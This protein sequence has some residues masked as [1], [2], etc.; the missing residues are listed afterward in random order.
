[1]V[2]QLI[3]TNITTNNLHISKDIKE[4]NF[5]FLPAQYIFNPGRVGAHWSNF[6]FLVRYIGV[7]KCIF[8]CKPCSWRFYNPP[9]YTCITMT[10][11]PTFSSLSRWSSTQNQGSVAPFGHKALPCRKFYGFPWPV[12]SLVPVNHANG[13]FPTY[14]QGPS[15]ILGLPTFIFG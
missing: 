7:I 3:V 10:I 13:K 6:F 11:F 1:M 2:G 14:S 4:D 5:L 8:E 12:P 15:A 9:A